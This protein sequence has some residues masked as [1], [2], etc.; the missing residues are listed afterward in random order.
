[1]VAGTISGS[2]LWGLES[3]NL[4]P[5]ETEICVYDDARQ[6]LYFQPMNTHG[7]YLVPE[8][9]RSVLLGRPPAEGFRYIRMAAEHG[10]REAGLSVAYAF[11]KGNG[12]TVNEAEARMREQ[13][14]E[15][16]EALADAS[17]ASPELELAGADAAPER[18]AAARAAAAIGGPTDGGF[19]STEDR[20]RG[21]QPS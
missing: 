14:A 18:A 19:P 12:T 6:L 17:P 4:V 16:A 7:P 5:P 9:E 1:M 8:A 2:Y 21:N 15:Q 3:G 10:H 13:M 20:L 11:E